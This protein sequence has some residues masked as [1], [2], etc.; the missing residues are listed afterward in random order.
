MPSR[1]LP[2][3]NTTY[4][5]R[6]IKAFAVLSLCGIVAGSLYL[7]FG[8]GF[9]SN[10]PSAEEVARQL[11]ADIPAGTPVAQAAIRLRKHGF[12]VTRQTDAAWGERE[13]LDYLHGSKSKPISFS[14][15]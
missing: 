2:S 3:S 1:G 12:E 11:Q 6:A 9:E 14:A 10:L 7:C 13:H 5:R 15:E 4:G 8:I